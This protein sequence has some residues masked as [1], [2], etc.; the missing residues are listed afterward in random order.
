MIKSFVTDINGAKKVNELRDKEISNASD[1]NLYKDSINN[2]AKKLHPGVLKARLISIEAVGISAKKFRFEAVDQ[3]FPPFEAGQYVSIEFDVNDTLTTRPYSILSAPYEV[4]AINPYFEIVIKRT[5]NGLVSNY[6]LDKASIGD[7]F[8][9]DFPHGDFYYEPLRDSKHIIGIAGGSGITPFVSIARSI[10]HGNLDVDLTIIYGFKNYDEAILLDELNEIMSKTDK[11]RVVNVV[12][13]K[14]ATKRF[15]DEEGFITREI[16]QKYSINEDPK[17][18]LSTYFI[19]GSRDMEIFVKNELISLNVPFRRIR[20]E[21]YG[22]R[23]D[24]ETDTDFDQNN[25]DKFFNILVQRGEKENVIRCQATESIA[26]AL[27]RYHIKVNTCCRSGSCGVCRFKVLYGSYFVPK[28]R[29]K[30]RKADIR[31]NYCHACQ[32]YPTSDMKIKIDIL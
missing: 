9:V 16:I 20:S 22:E 18:G 19:C 25:K 29:D 2:L 27:E 28:D 7:I 30:R 15:G 32:T 12:S 8:N 10:V 24:Y 4:K 13:D 3:Y 6:M 31:F 14:Y 26:R 23:F 21:L 11:V 1:K 5:P 17:S